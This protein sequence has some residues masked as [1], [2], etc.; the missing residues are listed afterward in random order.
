MNVDGLN[1]REMQ[2]LFAVEEQQNTP[3]GGEL[4]KDQFL[5]LL[6]AQMS[7]QDPLSPMDSRDSIAQLAQFSAL[8][9]MQNLNEQVEALRHAGGL[10]DGALLQGAPVEAVLSHG[11]TLHGVIERMAWTPSEGLLVHIDGMPISIKDI[12]ELRVLTVED[13]ESDDA[14]T[15]AGEA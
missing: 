8:E 11:E 12:S 5:E 15:D 4:G 6:V 9:Q 7:Q 10:L 1:E 3:P 2:T 14:G 13:L